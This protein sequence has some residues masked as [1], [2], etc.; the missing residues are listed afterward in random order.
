MKFGTAHVED[1]IEQYARCPFVLELTRIDWGLAMDQ[2]EALRSSLDV[3]GPMC[4][5]QVTVRLLLLYEVH[6]TT[7]CARHISKS[8]LPARRV[9]LR[10]AKQGTFGHSSWQSTLAS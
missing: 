5:E 1:I 9:M 7:S 3:N 8:R 6:A 4:E 2:S 10:H